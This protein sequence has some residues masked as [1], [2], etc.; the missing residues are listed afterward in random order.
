MNLSMGLRG[1]NDGTNG[2]R[3]MA[4][5]RDAAFKFGPC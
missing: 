5:E 2:H 4:S 1:K 3:A